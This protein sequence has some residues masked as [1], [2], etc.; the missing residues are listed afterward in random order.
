[1]NKLIKVRLFGSN[2]CDLC[3]RTKS[4]LDSMSI[5]YEFVDAILDENQDLCDLHSV[6]KLPHIQ[7]YFYDTGKILKEHRGYISPMLFI[8][9]VLGKSGK[10]KIVDN[11]FNKKCNGCGNGNSKTTEI[12]PDMDFL[13]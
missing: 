10:K 3:S 11:Y 7:L 4:E 9:N 1:L 5:D 12:K 6:E 2:T 13:N 8:S